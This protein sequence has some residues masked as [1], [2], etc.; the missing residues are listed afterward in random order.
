MI[1]IIIFLY[2]LVPNNELR[3]NNIT[4]AENKIL[5]F[6]SDVDANPAPRLTN[7]NNINIVKKNEAS[8]LGHFLVFFFFGFWPI[9]FPKTSEIFIIPTFAPG[10]PGISKEGIWL[11]SETA[12]SISFS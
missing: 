2:I 10:I 5:S 9:D 8:F 11:L 4:R 7:I 3:S 12:I 6:M 1:L